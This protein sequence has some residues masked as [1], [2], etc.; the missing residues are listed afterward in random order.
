MALHLPPTR[1]ISNATF[2]PGS[3]AGHFRPPRRREALGRALDM[4][5]ENLVPS[6]DR[7]PG[8]FARRPT[9]GSRVAESLQ[10]AMELTVPRPADLLRRIAD[11][12]PLSSALVTITGRNGGAASC[13]PLFQHHPVG[14]GVRARLQS[15]TN[16][17][18]AQRLVA[19]WA[20]TETEERRRIATRV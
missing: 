18:V 15:R 8:G 16:G 14:A 19:C 3:V 1:P 9:T 4:S 7:R 12:P 6:G 17:A 5:D 11:H 10:R 20:S 2:P 13:R